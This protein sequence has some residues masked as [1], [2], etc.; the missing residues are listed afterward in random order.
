M[1]KLLFLL[2]AT[3]LLGS[4][5]SA[6]DKDTKCQQIGTQPAAAVS[7]DDAV[8]F[9]N[10][11][12]CNQDLVMLQGLVPAGFTP[13]PCYYPGSRHDKELQRWQKDNDRA[14]K[15]KERAEQKQRE[16]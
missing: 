1:K 9:K 7:G 13:N 8:W 2:S 12:A 16:N 3:L 4:C 11:C 14:V 6:E 5:Q 10:N 15:E